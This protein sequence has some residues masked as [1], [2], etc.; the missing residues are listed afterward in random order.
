MK[1]RKR[2]PSRLVLVGLLLLSACGCNAVL[3]KHPVG[4][5]PA[6]IETNEWE[7][8][9]T[10]SDGAVRLQVLDADKGILKAT[11]VEDGKNGTPA[12]KSAQIE[13]RESGGW[14]IASA[15]EDKGRGYLWG[16]I[17]NEDRQIIVWSPDER[18]FAQAVKDGVLPGRV[19]GE[20]VILDDLKPHHLKVITATEKGV[21]FS[22]DRPSI[23]VKSGN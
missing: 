6:R 14:L 2:H 19:E 3:S 16:R 1:L 5:N 13:V 18:L 21:L 11:W 17:K 4:D 8:N 10:T 7:G 20:D 9:W 12:L 23:F 22:W 15:R